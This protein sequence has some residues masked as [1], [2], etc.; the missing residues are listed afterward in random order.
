M[1]K[2]NRIQPPTRVTVESLMTREVRC[3][4]PEMTIHQAIGV[5]LTHTV[6]GAPVVDE[7]QKVLSVVSEGDLL[8]LASKRGLKTTIRECFDQLVKTEGLFSL[9]KSDGFAHAY[10]KALGHPVHRFIVVD[11]TGKLEGIVSRSNI[12]RV[13]FESSATEFK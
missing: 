13:V 4:Q 9:R 12:L 2:Q 7:N 1:N 5:L 11:D 6:A 3:V 10:M 8:R